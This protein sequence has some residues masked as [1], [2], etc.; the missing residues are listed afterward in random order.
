[1][2]PKHTTRHVKTKTSTGTSQIH[3]Q[4]NKKGTFKAQATKAG[5]SVQAEAQK[6]LA[7]PTASPVMKKKA[8]FARNFAK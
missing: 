6:V 2:K 4:P 5:L 7:S 3:I 8:N 1:M